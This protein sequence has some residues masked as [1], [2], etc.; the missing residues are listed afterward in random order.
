MGCCGQ[1][2]AVI[3]QG[4]STGSQ[5]PGI[6]GTSVTLRFTQQAAVLIRGPVTGRHYPFHGSTSTQRVDARDAIAL[7]KSGYFQR[8]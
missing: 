7:M 5:E 2:R 4:K 6:D 8:A 1:Q 3:V